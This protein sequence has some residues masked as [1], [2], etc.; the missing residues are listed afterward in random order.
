M[1]FFDSDSKVNT[2]YWIFDKELGLLINPTNVEAQKI[3][4][5]I[6]NTYGII[7]AA[8]SMINKVYQIRNFK[9]IFLVANVSLK[10]V[11]RI[12]FLTLSNAYIDFLDWEF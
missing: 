8:F 3:N 5:I 4:G 1:I 10:I 7:V 9:K 11:F 2:I 6:L 12:F